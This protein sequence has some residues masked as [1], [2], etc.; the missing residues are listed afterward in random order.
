MLTDI[1]A[2]SLA[3]RIRLGSRGELDV[4]LSIVEGEG[5]IT[6][7]ASATSLVVS[8]TVPAD[9]NAG[10]IGCEIVSVGAFGTDA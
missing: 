10:I 5:S 4:A 6:A 7:C 3:I 1:A 2:P 8:I 9:C